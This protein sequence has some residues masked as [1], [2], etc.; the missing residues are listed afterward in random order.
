MSQ[1]LRIIDENLNRLSEGLRVLEDLARMLFNDTSLTQQ[2]KAMRHNLVETDLKINTQLVQSRDSINDIGAGM[3]VGKETHKELSDVL[4][5]N[6]RR[7]QESLRVLEE[8]AKLPVLN[9]DSNKYKKARFD[10]YTI[11][12]N[13][14]SRIL[15]QDKLK[16]L[17]GLY[18]IIDTHALQKRDPIVVARQ[19]IRGGAKIIQFRDKISSKKE[20]LPVALKLRD[21]CS[22][23]DVL[24]I[25]NDY[26]DLAL[27][28][29]ADG[30]HVGQDDL[31][32]SVAR[33]ELP[34]DKIIGCS[35][36]SFDQSII[37][38]ADGADYL[39]VGSVFPT[40]SK[41]DIDVCGLSVLKQITQEIQIPV[42]AIGGINKNN[43][44]ETLAAGADAVAVISAVLQAAD[45]ETAVRE[46]VGIIKN[47]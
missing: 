46:L 22:R 6:A 19:I 34:I 32:V 8:M 12:C 40:S 30:L 27:A 47:E 17:T 45:P 3:T 21:L 9:L 23:S 7:S 29:A 20:L 37:A 33:R 10:L 25:I 18:A 4:I 13:L 24:F 11:E 43:I 36:T 2:L 44:A 1:T 14:L 35:V 5:A 39:G 38:V 41:E 26:L 15:R 42:V 16:M 28:T 31:P